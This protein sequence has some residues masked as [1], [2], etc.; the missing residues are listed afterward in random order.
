MPVTCIFSFFPQSCQKI[1][2]SGFLKLTSLLLGIISSPEHEVL[3]VKYCDRSVV[4][5]LS[6]R[7]SVCLQLQKKKSSSPKLTIRF[8]PN[9]IEMI[10]R[11][12]FF[13][14]LQRIEFREELWLPWQQSEKNFKNLLVPNCKG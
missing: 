4:R 11:S 5:R 3:E 2:P 14:I 7:P 10:L 13:I 6:V 8:Q 1:F 12:C 9:V